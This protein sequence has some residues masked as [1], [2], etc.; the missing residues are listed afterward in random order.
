[1]TELEVSGERMIED[2]YM[3]S[4]DA[5]VIYIMHT[6]SYNFA[7]KFCD[8][9]VVLD[10]GCGSGY[11][12]ARMAEHAERVVGVDVD[13]DAIS[14][15]RERY[16]RQNVSFAKIET[17]APLPFTDDSFDVVLSFQVIEHVLDD[18]G[19]MKEAHR[20]L[21][22]G[23]IMVVVTPDR[24]H[25]LLPGQLP[26][27]RWHV[28]EYSSIQLD[29]KMKECFDLEASLKMGADWNVAG[30][31]I[32]RYRK[33][34]WLTLPFTL[35]FVPGLLRRRG[36]DF[37]HKLRAKPGSIGA[38]QT[39]PPMEFDFDEAA[40]LIEDNPPNSLNLVVVGRKKGGCSS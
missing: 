31:E 36:L 11:G 10:L 29:R 8:G 30:V 35:P 13:S 23:G 14:F 32:R 9:K 2:A 19:Y 18:S 39:V 7:K 1:M 33:T 16:A 38:A 12:V 4:L 27:N 3:Q 6:A 22:P 37:L 34:K 5:Y 15:A 25:R 28:R 21:K 20:V 24:K 40:M 17:E 26:W